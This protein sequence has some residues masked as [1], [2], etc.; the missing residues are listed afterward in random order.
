MLMFLA[1]LAVAAYNRACNYEP[2]VRSQGEGIS[3]FTLAGGKVT[4]H[5]YF[6]YAMEI[7]NSGRA[8][9]LARNNAAK[10]LCFYNSLQR[11]H[12]NNSTE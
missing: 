6:N 3:S 2:R 4:S 8:K 5:G 1:D 11:N 10:T 12:R 7:N 9:R